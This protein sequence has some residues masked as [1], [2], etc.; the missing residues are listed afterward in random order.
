MFDDIP[1]WNSPQ[2]FKDL[3]SYPYIA[4]DFIDKAIHYLEMIKERDYS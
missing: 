1:I 3:S 2:E 4:I